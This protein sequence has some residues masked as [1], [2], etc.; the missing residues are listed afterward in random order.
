MALH[1]T[2]CLSRVSSEKLAGAHSGKQQHSSMWAATM[3]PAP[4]QQMV[5]A[6]VPVEQVGMEG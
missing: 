3:K 6:L 1:G 2:R 4:P 5:G